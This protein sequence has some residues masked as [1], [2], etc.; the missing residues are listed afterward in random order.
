MSGVNHFSV[1][2]FALIE[3]L[4]F[5]VVF[6]FIGVLNKVVFIVVEY[7]FDVVFLLE[8]SG[9]LE[10]LDADKPVGG[11]LVFDEVSYDFVESEVGVVLDEVDYILQIGESVLDVAAISGGDD[12]AMPLFIDIG[13]EFE[14]FIDVDV[15]GVE[16]VLAGQDEAL[17][18][19]LISCRGFTPYGPD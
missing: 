7:S 19:G 4:V 10:S 2:I 1:T 9:E 11:G 15:L 13:Y 6:I 17:L 14:L 3:F 12:G 5:I 8:W 18:V 16:I